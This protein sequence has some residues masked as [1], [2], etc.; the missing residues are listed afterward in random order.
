MMNYAPTSFERKVG[1][2]SGVIDGIGCKSY[3]YIKFKLFYF[4]LHFD[5]IHVEVR[6]VFQH[7]MNNIYNSTQL[8]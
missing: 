6:D 1:V 4:A 7:N 5:I 2:D 8:C 3:G